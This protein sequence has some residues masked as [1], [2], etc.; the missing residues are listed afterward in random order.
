MA[1]RFKILGNYESTD[2][3]NL[4]AQIFAVLIAAQAFTDPAEKYPWLMAVLV[5]LGS[6]Y[7]T[8]LAIAPK[9]ILGLAIL[10]ASL[11]FIDPA[12]GGNLFNNVAV[13]FFAHTVLALL[14]AA[15]AYT[16]LRVPA[17]KN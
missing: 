13:F 9:S 3:P 7:L 15:A 10:P 14:F 1:N 6:A 16:Y 4:M 11:V 12:I 8:Y 5:I 2:K 17:R